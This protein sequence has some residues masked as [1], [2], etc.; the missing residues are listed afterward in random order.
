[1]QATVVNSGVLAH[2]TQGHDVA[3]FVARGGARKLDNLRSKPAVTVLWRAGWAW[4]CLEG[5][6]ELCGPEDALAG[7]D[8]EARR[9]LLRDVFS[10]AGGKHEDWAEYDRVMAAEGRTAVLVTPDR[11]Y[12]NP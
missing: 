10:S 12:T 4:V 3:G 2:P 5:R 1:M 11:I 8:D 9:V 7:V 6:A